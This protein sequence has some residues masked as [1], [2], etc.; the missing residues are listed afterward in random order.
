MSIRVCLCLVVSKPCCLF[1]LL[2]VPIEVECKARSLF[3]SVDIPPSGSEPRFEAIGVFE[4]S[5]FLAWT[6]T[7]LNTK[8]SVCDSSF[9]F[10][11]FVDA[12]GAYPVTESYGA[13]CGYTYS[14][15]PLLGRVILRASYF[16]CHTDNQVQFTSIVM[17]HFQD[18]AHLSVI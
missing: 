17:D 3:V 8:Q 10:G 9:F 18:N 11:L 14:V 6:C 2:I 7:V 5:P 16:S 15:H 13:Q 12:T 1:V 4:F